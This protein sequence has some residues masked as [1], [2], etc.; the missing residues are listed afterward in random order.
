MSGVDSGLGV[1]GSS[2]FLSALLSPLANARSTG[3]THYNYPGIYQSQDFHY[4]GTPGDDIQ[5]W[6]NRTQVQFCELANL[7]ECVIS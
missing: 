2:A 6:S 4:C 1:A 5:D 7:A 3:F